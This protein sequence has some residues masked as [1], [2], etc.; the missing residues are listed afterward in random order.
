MYNKFNSPAKLGNLARIKKRKRVINSKEC[1]N[2]MKDVLEYLFSAFHKAVRMFNDEISKTPIL[3]RARSMEAS[4]FNSKLL[5]CLGEIFESDL[6]CGKYGRR[7]LYK[8]GYIVLFK[9][10]NGK[11]M[12]M[13]I[14][15][16]LSSSI[17]N[18]MEGNLFNDEEDGT[19]PIIF[20]GYSKSKFGEITHPQIV[21]I[22]EGMVKWRLDESLIQ[23]HKVNIDSPIITP[24]R[25][26][27][28]VNVKPLAKEKRIIRK[29]E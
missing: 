14:K 24:Q 20:F 22:D 28:N 11:H 19:S 25:P 7:F 5:Q 26:S 8:N 15:T 12:P 1:Q 21:Y 27:G 17:E 23:L 18:Q 10:L 29:I 4:Y 9:K 13:N 2:D 6:K 3:Y 16:K